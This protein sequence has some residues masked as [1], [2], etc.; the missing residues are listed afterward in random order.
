MSLQLLMRGPADP[1][2]RWQMVWT[3]LEVPIEASNPAP[4]EEGL[5]KGAELPSWQE[6]T[7]ARAMAAKT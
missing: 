7:A 6:A 2:D 5:L 1:P 3:N 4:L